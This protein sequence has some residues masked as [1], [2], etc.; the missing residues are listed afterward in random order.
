[1]TKLSIKLA[2]LG[3]VVLVVL[4]VITG[5]LDRI[6]TDKFKMEKPFWI[7]N[8]RNQVYDFAVIGSSR[9]ENCTDV[10]TIGTLT[11]KRGVNLGVQGACF[12]DNLIMLRRFLNNGNRTELLLI[13]VDEYALDARN[14][15]LD[16]FKMHFYLPYLDD[17]W[18]RAVVKD[19]V[20]AERYYLWYYLPLT[21]YVE[22]NT[23][24][25]T[26]W[27]HHG[28][29]KNAFDFDMTNGSRLETNQN[30][31]VFDVAKIRKDRKTIDSK[32]LKYLNSLIAYAS[33]NGIKTVLFTAPQ[34][35]RKLGYLSNRSEFLEKISEVCRTRNLGYVNYEGDTVC[36]D[37]S[38]FLDASHLNAKGAVLFSRKLADVARILLREREGR[39]AGD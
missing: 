11:G 31:F 37:S 14:S 29:G 9:A 36:K 13:E 2:I 16:P 26:Y 15:F 30:P 35:Y 18:V 17:E 4:S 23:M 21:K 3:A 8:Q 6:S 10:G 38:M 20:R 33:A 28:L 27:L 25:L 1:M 7:M 24:Y 39:A 12:A 34:Y 19:N 22:Y 5:Y 32:D